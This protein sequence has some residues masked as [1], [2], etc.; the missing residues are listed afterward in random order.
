MKKIIAPVLMAVTVFALFL[1]P[2][3]ANAQTK[4]SKKME[5]K[6]ILF[7]YRAMTKKETQANQPVIIWEKLPMPGKY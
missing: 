6:K 2:D 5:K 1:N 4:K 7:V 3:L